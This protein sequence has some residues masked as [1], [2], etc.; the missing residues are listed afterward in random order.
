MINIIYDKYFIKYLQSI[1]NYFYTNIWI[2]I[3]YLPIASELISIKIY[4]IWEKL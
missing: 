3:N 4:I 1:I 2:S